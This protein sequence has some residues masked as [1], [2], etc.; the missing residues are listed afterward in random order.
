MSVLGCLVRPHS[1]NRALMQYECAYDVMMCF[2]SVEM[3][4]M[5]V[6]VLD[7]F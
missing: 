4:V 3:N 1:S 6:L 7:L 5:A 2:Y